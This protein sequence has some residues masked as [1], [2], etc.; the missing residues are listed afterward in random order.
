MLENYT[1]NKHAILKFFVVF[2]FFKVYQYI[3]N[4]VINLESV[5]NCKVL[6][7]VHT[8]SAKILSKVGI[9]CKTSDIIVGRLVL[10]TVQCWI[11][12]LGGLRLLADI[13]H[14][15]PVFT[16]VLHHFIYLALSRK[17][18]FSQNRT[19]F[20]IGYVSMEEMKSCHNV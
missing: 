13:K 5:F 4:M 10:R 2:C 19:V 9:V 3:C 18:T 7:L 8:F 15:F 12:Y 1:L 6:C 14:F 17:F 11:S 16:I 20:T